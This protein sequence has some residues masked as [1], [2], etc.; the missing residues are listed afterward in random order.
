V[1]TTRQ[2]LQWRLLGVAV[3]ATVAVPNI[4]YYLVGYPQEHWQVD[5]E[6]YREGAR[7][8]LLGRE[9]YDWLTGGPQWLPFTYPPLAALLGLP[10]L[11]VSF[12][13][14][15]W[16]WTAIQLWL[17]WF[18]V[19]V[20][21]RPF[22]QRFG[23]RRWP[24]QGVVAGALLYTLP[25]SDGIRFGQVNAVI[26][27]LCLVDLARP[28][29]GRWPRG[30]M[31]AIAAALKLTPGVFWVH[32]AVARRWRTLAC[33]VSIA[34]AATALTAMVL[35]SASAAYW[36]D[37]L[38]D[39]GRLGP[40]TGTSNQSLRGVLL[41][42]GPPAGPALTLTWLAL[43]A[44]VGAA[45]FALSARLD[46]LGEPVAVV[47]AVGMLAVLLSPVSWIHHLHWGIVVIGAVL[48]DGRQ[49]RRVATAGAGTVWLWL[50]LPWWGAHMVVLGG[51][52]RW[53]ARL[54]QNSYTLFA[55]VALVALWLLV[56]RGRSID[57][58]RAPQG[59]LA[60]QPGVATP[61]AVSRLSTA[62]TAQTAGGR[63]ARQ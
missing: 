61:A 33:S 58:E 59:P 4:R 52:P 44:V 2:V 22:L 15:G 36:T 42:L 18:S 53:V 50:R 45:G 24:V 48:G 28:G 60:G 57:A 46:R 11:L 23:V 3:F 13:A 62:M 47:A 35:P 30:S 19:G 56:A 9:V 43:L 14:A 5:L 16:M 37:A 31:V 12:H 25:V 38:L 17:L 41:R 55:L 21:F 54:M 6:V 7:S 10:L 1:T 8:L 26:V 34:A 39:P 51:V 40:N 32:W 27:A 49:R 20:A 63:R 29:R